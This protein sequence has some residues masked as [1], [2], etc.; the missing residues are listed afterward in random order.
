MKHSKFFLLALILVISQ[1]TY[2]Q[3]RRPNRSPFQKSVAAERAWPAF[4]SRL[5]SAVKRRDRARL[6]GMM[7]PEFRYTLGH[8][9]SRREIDSREDAFKYWDDPNNPT[10]NDLD[11]TLAKG[12]VPMAAWWREGN[13]ELS[14]PTRVAPPAGN[15]KWK[16]DKGRVHFIAL[17]EYRNGRWYFTLFDVCCD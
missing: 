10:W 8:H 9:A 16:V 17:F 13:Q 12:A 6:K 14:P 15:I 5:K 1:I 4:F 3:T 7:I 2:T 11:R